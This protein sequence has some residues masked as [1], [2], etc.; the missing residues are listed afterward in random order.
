ML[1]GVRGP[2]RIRHLGEVAAVVAVAELA[3]E[4]VEPGPGRGES[5]LLLDPGR[6]E[7]TEEP[8]LS[9]LERQELLPRWGEPVPLERLEIAAVL[10]IHA[11]GKVEIDDARLEDLPAAAGLFL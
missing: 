6:R 5:S 7:G 3:L 2:A 9:R 4:E 11:G 8:K 1:A 10:P